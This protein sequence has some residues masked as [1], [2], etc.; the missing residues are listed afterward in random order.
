MTEKDCLFCKIIEGKIPSSIVYHK[1]NVVG[2]KDASPAAPVHLLFVHKN[3]TRDLN[4]ICAK[5]PKGLAEL[6]D[7]INQ[8]TQE[9]GI[10]D[11]GY[12]VVTNVGKWA[13]Q[14]I[15]HTHFH[16]LSGGNLGKFGV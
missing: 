2:F 7:G 15:F 11:P 1:G 6:I 10:T 8:F 12:R 16:V 3:H 14:T 13:G 5:D 4:D 9:S